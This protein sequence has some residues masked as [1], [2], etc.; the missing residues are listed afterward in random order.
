M[1][2]DDLLGGGRFSV[3][4]RRKTVGLEVGAIFETRLFWDGESVV[5]G[6]TFLF[7]PPDAREQ[8]LRLVDR[9]VKARGQAQDSTELLFKLSRAHVKWHR[10]G[11]L[12]AA[13]V[14][15]MD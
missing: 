3:L 6:K 5:F 4:E 14:Y 9:T 10:L 12:S 13:K 8:V 15:G 11:H 7:H 2:V 1:E